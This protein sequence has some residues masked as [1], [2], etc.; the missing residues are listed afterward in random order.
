MNGKRLLGIG[1]MALTL[2][3]GSINLPGALAQEN[4]GQGPPMENFIADFDKDKDGKVSGEEFPGPAEHFKDL[5]RNADGYVDESEA[6]NGPP[7]GGP[8]GGRFIG[9]LDKDGDK[10]VSQ[11]EFKVEADELFGRLDKNKDGFIDY[12]EAPRR[13]PGHGRRGQ[14]GGKRDFMAD[15]DKDADGKVAKSEFDGPEKLFERLDR[16]GDGFVDETE[17]PKGKGGQ[18][19]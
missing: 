7:A 11:A 9:R 10:K 19:G 13:G 3:V 8:D 14:E 16:N 4:P 18:R 6:P 2:S 5:D 17:T 15:F 1:F 12:S